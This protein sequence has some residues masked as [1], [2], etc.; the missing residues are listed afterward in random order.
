ML[1]SLLHLPARRSAST[2]KCKRLLFIFIASQVIILIC[3]RIV[4]IYWLFTVK[5]LIVVI[6]YASLLT[7]W[8]GQS[9]ALGWWTLLRSQLNFSIIEIIMHS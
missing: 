3:V 8:R 1:S 4:A 9:I 2:W 5:K 6:H 7:L